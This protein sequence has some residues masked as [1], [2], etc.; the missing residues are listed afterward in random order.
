MGVGAAKET[1]RKAHCGIRFIQDAEKID[2]DGTLSHSLSAK[3]ASRPIVAGSCIRSPHAKFLSS[4]LPMSY[5]RV[6]SI[7]GTP[8]SLLTIGSALSQWVA[9][10]G[11]RIVSVIL[12]ALLLYRI[13]RQALDRT[14]TWQRGKETGKR[15]TLQTI[16]LRVLRGGFLA[17][18][19]LL[20]LP[21]LGFTISPLLASLGI[22]GLALSFGTQTLVRDLV[23]GFFLIAEDLCRVGEDIAIE[24]IRGR[25]EGLR[26]R[27]IML[28][29][30]NGSAIF[31]PYGEIKTIV[32]HSRKPSH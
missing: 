1:S 4:L 17:V 10:H 32:N 29:D 7:M 25:V 13:V 2:E 23:A 24:N 11:L 8:P 31:I 22:A 9:T 26:L 28:R 6:A 30:E 21:E 27:T 20:I 14:F 3:T 12:V 19:A 16:L 18:T 5:H 15:T